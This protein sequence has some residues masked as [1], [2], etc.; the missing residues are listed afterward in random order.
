VNALNNRE[1]PQIISVWEDCAQHGALLKFLHRKLMI[2]NCKLY[3]INKVD[4]LQITFERFLFYR[5]LSITG[6]NSKKNEN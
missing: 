2:S 3:K 1:R 4:E 6:H 5:I